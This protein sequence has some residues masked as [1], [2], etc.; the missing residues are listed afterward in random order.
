MSQTQRAFNL[1]ESEYAE[2][3]RQY[4]KDPSVTTR[5]ITKG[6]KLLWT[7]AG[8]AVFLLAALMITNQT[9]L[10][11]T[12]Q[13]IQTLQDKLGNQSKLTQQL[14]A[15]ADSLSSPDRIVNFAEQQLGLKLDINNIKVLP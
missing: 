10:Y 9:K 11:L 7:L 8:V 13:D 15:D 6:E 14:K 5:H 1:P 2:P 12:S 4:V 3:R